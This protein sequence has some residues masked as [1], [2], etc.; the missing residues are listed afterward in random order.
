MK[1]KL[2]IIG[3]IG[4][5]IIGS[6]GTVG[7]NFE[8]QETN[9]NT[10]NILKEK[11]VKLDNIQPLSEAAG[12]VIFSKGTKSGLNPQR[13]KRSNIFLSFSINLL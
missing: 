12:N 13:I 1:Q 3:I 10:G 4:L 11:D 8:I 6:I 5:L 9:K 7:A 2:L